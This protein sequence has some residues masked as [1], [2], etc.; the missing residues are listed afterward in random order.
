MSFQSDRWIREQAVNHRM[1][2]PFSERQV[3]D[4]VLAYGLSSRGYDL[5]VSSEFTEFADVNSAIIDP[6]AFDGRSFASVHARSV[7]VP[8]DSSA[9]AR[10][11]EYVRI[12]WMY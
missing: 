8:P 1:I 5:R 9:W 3:H 2:Q 7:I 10:S 6:K 11:I 12:P 4:G